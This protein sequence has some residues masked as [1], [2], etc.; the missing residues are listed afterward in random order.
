[1]Q[2]TTD[3]NMDFNKDADSASMDE[4]EVSTPTPT[5]IPGSTPSRTGALSSSAAHYSTAG[6]LPRQ[7]QLIWIGGG[8][9]GLVLLSALLMMGVTRCRRSTGLRASAYTGFAE[10]QGPDY[11]QATKGSAAPPHW[12]ASWVVSGVGLGDSLSAPVEP[13]A[14]PP[15][16]GNMDRVSLVGMPRLPSTLQFSTDRR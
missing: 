13:A 3:P 1:M 16:V 10:A 12:A 15:G 7:E 5:P 8:A 14:P 2:S 6:A 4:S 11:L 9:A